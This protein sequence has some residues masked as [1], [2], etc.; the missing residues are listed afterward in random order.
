MGLSETDTLDSQM[1]HELLRREAGS[2]HARL[3]TSCSGADY[4]Y[5]LMRSRTSLRRDS[6]LFWRGAA[7]YVMHRIAMRRLR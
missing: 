3:T 7:D 4:L 1:A 5:F 6:R 2:E